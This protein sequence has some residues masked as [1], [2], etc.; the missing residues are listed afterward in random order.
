LESFIEDVRM[1]SHD[2]EHRTWSKASKL[3]M[4]LQN[5]CARLSE[6]LE[7]YIGIAELAKGVH[8][9][10]GSLGYGVI[11]VLLM[12]Q[13]RNLLICCP[14]EN[15]G[16]TSSGCKE[17]RRPREAYFYLPR[18]CGRISARSCCLAR[19]L[20]LPELSISLNGYT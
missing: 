16:L 13:R 4:R 3:R 6:F 1:Q 8:S 17:Q 20:S 18:M 19:H 10:G 9:Q 5:V 15:E 14:F 2:Y 11:S 12:V 7:C